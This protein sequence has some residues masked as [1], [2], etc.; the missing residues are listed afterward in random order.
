MALLPMGMGSSLVLT[1]FAVS[2]GAL[3]GIWHDLILFDRAVT[4]LL[5]SPSLPC[6]AADPRCEEEARGSVTGVVQPCP[7]TEC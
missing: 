6:P 7:G 2:Q 1:V 3:A 5:F 4:C